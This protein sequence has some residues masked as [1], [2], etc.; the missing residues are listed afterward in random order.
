MTEIYRKDQKIIDLL[1]APGF[2]VS[3][4]VIP[5]RNGTPQSDIL[6]QINSLVRAGAQFLSVTK[7]AGGSLRGGSLPIAQVIKDHFQ[8]P[9]I[10]HFT[11][12]DLTPEECENQLMDHHYFGIRNIL[13]LRGDP[14][15]GVKDWQPN[16]LSYPYAYQL[17]E[18]IQKLNQGHFLE[19]KSF[20]NKSKVE[21]D[22]CIGAASYPEEPEF[23]ARVGYFKQ[24]VEAG[25]CYS[26]TQMLYDA[27]AYSRFLD[28][29][30][31][32]KCSVPVLPGARILKT[33]A[34]AVRMQERFQIQVPLKVLNKLPDEENAEQ[35]LEVFIEL[36]E[37]FKRRGAPGVHVFVLSDTVLSSQAIAALKS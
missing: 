7:G 26:I 37:D 27:E 1:L 25:A 18:Q 28:E 17:I 2:T 15:V 10:A 9:S 12:R 3:A 31:R 22:F 32:E 20:Q 16:P 24:K 4:E 14:P 23:A 11:C 29:I 6:N 34:Q 8:V 33:K 30:G 5:P 36:V 13:G 21:T 35:A 19:R